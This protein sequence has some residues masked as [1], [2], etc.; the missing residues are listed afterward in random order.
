MSRAKGGQTVVQVAPEATY[1]TYV[2]P[3]MVLPVTAINVN[4]EYASIEGKELL[5]NRLPSGITPGMQTITGDFTIL[6][7]P[8]TMP[9]LI[10]MLTG[11]EGTSTSVVADHVY[12]HTFDFVAEPDEELPSFSMVHYDGVETKTYQGCKIESIKPSVDPENYLS[13]QVTIKGQRMT[14]SGSIDEGLVQSTKGKYLFTG[15]SFKTGTAGAEASSALTVA[16][17]YSPT[18]SN[19]LEDARYRMTGN[20]YAEEPTYQ[21]LS[22]EGDLECDYGSDVQTLITAWR[23]G[24]YISAKLTFQQKSAFHTEAGPPE[25]PYYYKMELDIPY[26]AITNAPVNVSANEALS[27]TLTTR[28]VNGS[29]LPTVKLTDAHAEE[30]YAV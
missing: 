20:A 17:S 9:F 11:I 19:S 4:A 16:K 8:D 21:G 22:I 2:A 28:A 25:V 26:L 6:P 23:A 7:D 14:S 13:F 5:G 12:T 24:T 15:T 3:T 1:G 30:W 27:I 18:I 10:Y 29:T